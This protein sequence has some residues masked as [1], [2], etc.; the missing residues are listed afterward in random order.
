VAPVEGRNDRLEHVAAGLP[1]D[2][3]GI[4]GLTAAGGGA[5]LQ[6]W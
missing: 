2:S 1:A 6:A 4:R 5:G 3:P